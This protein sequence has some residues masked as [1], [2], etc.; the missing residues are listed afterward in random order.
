M[1]AN[2]DPTPS[3]QDSQ[4]TVQTQSLYRRPAASRTA[5]NPDPVLTP[6]KMLPSYLDA[7][8]EQR[9]SLT[10]IAMSGVFPNLAAQFT[11]NMGLAH[12][13]LSLVVEGR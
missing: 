6:G 8:V 12:D 1:P 10:R 2:A 4:F 7:R 9:N 3:G 11:R 5:N 13:L